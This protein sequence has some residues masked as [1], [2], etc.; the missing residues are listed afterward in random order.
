MATILITGGTGYIGRHLVARLVAAGERPRCLVRPGARLAGLPVGKV[1]LVNGDITDAATMPAALQGADAVVHAA[2]VVANLKE[3]KAVSY[4]RINDEGTANMVAA[5]KAAGLRNFI[6]IGGINTVPG[7]PDSYIRT[8]YDGEQHVKSSGLP[9]S[10]LQPSILFGDGAAFF[11]ALAS[12][13]RIAPIVPVP[14]NG[15]LRFQPIWVEDVVTCLTMLLAEAP[16]CETI[17]IGGPA[18][19]SYD[20][21]LDLIFKT[22]EK[23]RLKIHLPMP[24]MRWATATMQTVLPRPPATTATLELFEAGLDNVTA[25]DA[26]QAR[27][28]FQPK[29]L[30]A[31]LQEHGI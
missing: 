19:Y 1:E 16:R 21:L 29:S 17:A 30:E 28:G 26:V 6:H 13:A 18:Q 15:K 23:R 5:A 10:I 8:R 22:I 3:T 11:T 31:D 20:E 24:L 14:G 7:E 4:K 2:A 12:L 27:F 25:L 9:Y